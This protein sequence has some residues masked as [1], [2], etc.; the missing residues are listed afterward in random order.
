MPLEIVEL[1]HSITVTKVVALVLN[2]AIVVWLIV[3]KH[4][5]GVRGGTDTLAESVD[6][7]EVL[8]SPTPAGS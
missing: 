8:A 7:A 3:A 5:F 4:L 1:T 6:W 2:L